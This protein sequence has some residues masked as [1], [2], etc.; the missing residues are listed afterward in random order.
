MATLAMACDDLCLLGLVTDLDLELAEREFPGI[1]RYH[2]AHPGRH[3]TFL[4]LMVAF[5]HDTDTACT[6]TR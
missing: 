6:G 5:V 4:E 2:A 1:S 3:R